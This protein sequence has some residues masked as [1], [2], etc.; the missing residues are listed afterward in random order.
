M[1]DA[2]SDEEDR[3][4]KLI[5]RKSLDELLTYC[6]GSCQEYHCYW[7]KRKSIKFEIEK[8]K[9]EEMNTFWS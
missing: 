2:Y 6:C 7:C 9:T 1:S 4:Q 5:K 3:K 8:A